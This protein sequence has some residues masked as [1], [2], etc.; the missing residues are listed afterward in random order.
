[1]SHLRGRLTV[2]I[3]DLLPTGVAGGKRI[4]HRKYR[5][6]QPFRQICRVWLALALTTVRAPRCG[7]HGDLMRM[8]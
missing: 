7:R 5:A 8:R 4:G 6:N 3:G 2:A 1:M